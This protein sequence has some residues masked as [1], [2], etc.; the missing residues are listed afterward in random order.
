MA[1]NKA[2][3]ATAI[4]AAFAAGQSGAKSQAQVAADIADAVD[5]YVKGATVTVSGTTASACTT[6]GAVGTCAAT[7]ALS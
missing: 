5:L 1:L 3:L 7:G 4:Q 2:T 6:G